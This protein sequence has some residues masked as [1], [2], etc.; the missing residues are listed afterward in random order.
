MRPKL[1]LWLTAALPAAVIFT[2]YIPA[3]Q[4]DFVNWDDPDYVYENINIRSLDIDFLRWSLTAV[5]ASNWHPLTLISLAADYSFWGQNPEGYHFTSIAIH[6]INSLLVFILTIRLINLANFQDAG[7]AKRSNRKAFVAGIVTSLLF[8]IHPLRA[9]SVAWV[10]ERKDVLS[11]FFFLSGI[12]VYLKYASCKRPRKSLYYCSCLVLFVLALMS[13]PMAA[14]LPI[15]L[16]ILDLYPLNRLTSDWCGRKWVLLEKVPFF[17]LSVLSASITIWA[18][19]STGALKASGIYPLAVRMLVAVRSYLFYAVK[20][21]APINLAPFYPYPARTGSF[22]FEYVGSLVLFLSVTLFC[23]LQL[24][25]EKLYFAVWVYYVAT[26][27]PVIG[28]VQV[29]GQAAADRYTYLPGLGPT[30]LMGLGAG[31]LFERCS[32]RLQRLAIIGALSLILVF[33]SA[34]TTKQISIWKDSVTLWTHEIKL[35]PDVAEP[36][37]INRG[38]AY[39]EMGDYLSAIKDLTR[40]IEIDPRCTDA[41]VSRGSAYNSLGNHQ[42]AI[43]DYTIGISL[44]P[45]YAE[46]FYGRGNV[47]YDKGYYQQAIEDYNSTVKLNPRY[48]LAYYNRGLAYKNS[49]RYQEAIKDL[50]IVTEL[51]PRYLKAYSV[52]ADIYSILNRQASANSED[53]GVV[54]K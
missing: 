40:A 27:I 44:N 24:K 48:T 42:Q 50:T 54:R 18:H 33:L 12:L 3:L 38:S 36:A 1:Y 31:H 19:N 8:G 43:K 6:S 21:L 47:Y 34:L 11:A 49:G 52:R 15:I 45:R 14:S 22:T 16:L 26:L 51:D 46:A 39:K 13:K 23:I 35:F 41:Y 37:Y 30:F 5:V 4:N 9:E 20:T 10:S 25:R 2:V 29:G 32:T 53:S 28:I 17:A 7:P